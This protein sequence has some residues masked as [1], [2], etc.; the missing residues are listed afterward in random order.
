MIQRTERDQSACD[1]CLVHLAL[2]CHPEPK[3]VLVIGGISGGI[4]NEVARYQS[5]GEIVLCEASQALL[6]VCKKYFTSS[7]YD[8]PKLRGLCTGSYM[9]H[10]KNHSNEYDVIIT[11]PKETFLQPYTNNLLM[12]AL[13]PNGI[14]ISQ[15]P[16]FWLELN[17][18]YSLFKYNK[19]L[20]PIVNLA[21]SCIPTSPFGQTTF[22]LRSLNPTTCFETPVQ[23]L[24]KEEVS[25]LCYYNYKIHNACFALPE[26]V[27]MYE[28]QSV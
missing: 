6:D 5:V 26:L 16:S 18:I 28:F 14:I 8:N 3:K 20:F 13:K 1:E 2:S 11:V 15:L 21:Y 23:Q 7:G 25:H 17:A 10:L 9:E 22:I 19:T 27:R 12:S 4:V 24:P